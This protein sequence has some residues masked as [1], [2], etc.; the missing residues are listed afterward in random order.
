MSKKALQRKVGVTPDG[1]IGPRTHRALK[2]RI[3]ARL[4]GARY[5]NRSTVMK[6]QA[7]LNSR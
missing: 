2:L 3:H 1:A 4:D 5:L 7:D 6:Q